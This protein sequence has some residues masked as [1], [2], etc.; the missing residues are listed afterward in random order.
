MPTYEYQCSACD[1]TF[2]A[3][4]AITAKALKKCPE[5]GGKVER[6][7]GA[8]SGIIFR[9]SGFYTTDY[10]SKDYKEQAKKEKASKEKQSSTSSSKD[11][12]K[13]KKTGDKKDS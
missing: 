5:C 11:D 3:F 10:R 2:E 4:Q 12:G 8:G 1:H 6:L 13:G 9:G 7:I